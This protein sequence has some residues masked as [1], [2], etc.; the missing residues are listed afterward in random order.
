MEEEKYKAREREQRPITKILSGQ[1]IRLLGIG[2]FDFFCGHP[3]FSLFLLFPF[4]SHFPSS[5]PSSHIH[6]LIPEYHVFHAQEGRCGLDPL[7]PPGPCP[8]QPHP[9]QRPPCQA[10]L[11]QQ[12]WCRGK[13]HTARHFPK[14][15]L[16]SQQRESMA[17]AGRKSGSPWKNKVYGLWTGLVTCKKKTL[18]RQR[19]GKMAQQNIYV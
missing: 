16:N 8:L 17:I 2:R 13:Y 6:P 14:L 10:R 4:P 3:F 9:C 11:Q 15:I 1:K 19:T 7:G 12:R 18:Q 5:L